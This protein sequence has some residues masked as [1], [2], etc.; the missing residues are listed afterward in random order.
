MEGDHFMGF[1]GQKVCTL[2]SEDWEDLYSEHFLSLILGGTKQQEDPS[3][4]SLTELLY[5]GKNST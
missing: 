3:I 5:L 2:I 4:Q 1:F